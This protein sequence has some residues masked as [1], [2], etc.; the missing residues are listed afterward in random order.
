VGVSVVIPAYNEEAAIADAIADI[1][2]HVLS[3]LPDAEIVA[4]NDGSRDRTG[5]ILDE[6]AAAESRLR[7]VH[8]PNGGHGSAI[9][10]GA[11]AARGEWLFFID[12]DRQISLD[13][14]GKLW[15]EAKAGA[16]A[17]FGVRRRRNDP[18]LRLWLTSLIRVAL[19]V[20][21]D[22]NLHDANVPFKLVQREDWRSARA[23]IPDDT[24]A[25]SLFLALFLARRG[26]RI[27]QL[28]I[29]HRER[30]TGE[31]SIKRWKLFRFCQRALGQLL[32][33]RKA[34]AR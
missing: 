28:D 13:A 23:L 31:V 2:A 17:A 4:V 3:L 21:F 18:R 24:L 19:R 5:A 14:F 30:E 25:P 22:A 16:D 10:A 33:F 9:I 7:V 15:A 29:E 1:R 11:D 32:A 26:L 8:K 27:A 34:L 12:S 6:I 20:L